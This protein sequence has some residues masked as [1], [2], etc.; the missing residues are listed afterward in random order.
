MIVSLWMRWWSEASGLE[1]SVAGGRPP[2]TSLT[3]QAHA[4]DRE[5]RSECAHARG[6]KKEFTHVAPP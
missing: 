4:R 2:P 6:E 5:P 1:G 3:E